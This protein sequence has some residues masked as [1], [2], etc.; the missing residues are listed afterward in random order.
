MRNPEAK[1]YIVDD[2]KAFRDSLRWLLESNGY[3][4]ESF[5]S[6]KEFLES[7]ISGKPGC[8]VLDIRMPEMTGLELQEKL[9]KKGVHIPVI[10]VTGHGDIP[11]AVSAVKQ[12]AMDFIEKPFNESDMLELIRNALVLDTQRR[13]ADDRQALISSRLAKLTFSER[14][15]MECVIAGKP[16]KII[17]DQFD[18]TVKTVEAH[19]AKV[20][21]KMEVNSLAELVQLVVGKRA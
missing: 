21:D 7:F 11:M 9:N 18:I 10:F 6:A 14:K 4:I 15:V 17:A 12:G 3:Q 2:D 16:N 19:R 1:I 8:L 5:A 20:M 13:E